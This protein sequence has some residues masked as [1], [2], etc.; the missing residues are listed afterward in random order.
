MI[1]EKNKGR[2]PKEIEDKLCKSINIKLTINDY[3]N[4]LDRAEKLKM[5]P[6]AYA[7][8]MLLHGKVNAPFSDEQLLLMRQLAGEANNVNQIAKHLNSGETSYKLYA[9][10]VVDKLKKLIYDS[11]KP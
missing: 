8:S 5:T 7:R 6:T 2:P 9:L 10:A 3:C 1:K 11:Q 4:I